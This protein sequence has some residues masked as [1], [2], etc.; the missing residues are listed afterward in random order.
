MASRQRRSLIVR[1][2]KKY[3]KPYFPNPRLQYLPFRRQYAIDGANVKLS[4]YLKFGYTSIAAGAYPV[5]VAASIPI[6][7]NF[8]W[9]TAAT[10][11]FDQFPNIT[12]TPV[13]GGFHTIEGGPSN[14][15]GWNETI[16]DFASYLVYGVRVSL[17]VYNPV[18]AADNQLVRWGVLAEQDF[19]TAAAFGGAACNVQGGTPWTTSFA[20]GENK[21]AQLKQSKWMTQGTSA[22]GNIPAS[23]RL[24]NYFS[25]AKFLGESEEVFRTKDYALLGI[26]QT[27]NAAGQAV[28]PSNVNVNNKGICFQVGAKFLSLANGGVTGI[29][30]IIPGCRIE[31]GLKYYVRL[32]DKRNVFLAN[33]PDV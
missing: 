20:A 33:N 9:H 29:T 13:A 30:A 4:T 23:I 1:Q 31:I 17:V 14:Y 5:G 21:W 28:G 16:Q 11:A 19:G 2:G 25:C 12:A 27:F 26:N 24:T 18:D 3:T 6:P 15:N 8:L 32:F 7:M 22:S 10:S